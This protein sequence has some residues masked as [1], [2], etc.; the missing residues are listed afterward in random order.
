MTEFKHNLR[1]IVRCFSEYSCY[2]SRDPL[3]YNSLLLKVDH[4][5]QEL[6]KKTLAHNA[7]RMQS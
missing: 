1:I 7:H 4:F 3:V 6:L 2:R 5:R